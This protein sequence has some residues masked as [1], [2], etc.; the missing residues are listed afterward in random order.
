MRNVTIVESNVEPNKE[1]LWFYNGKLKWFGPNGWEE[2]YSQALSPTTTPKPVVPPATT[3]TTTSTAPGPGVDT[4]PIGVRVYNYMDVTIDTIVFGANSV[5]RS[6]PANGDIYIE[7]VYPSTSGGNITLYI[8]ARGSGSTSSGVQV[9]RFLDVNIMGE[10]SG[11]SIEQYKSILNE[12]TI[13]IPYTGSDALHSI[14]LVVSISDGDTT[15]TSSPIPGSDVRFTNNTNTDIQ[16]YGVLY[17]GDTASPPMQPG[18]TYIL[19]YISDGV[20]VYNSPNYMPFDSLRIT[21]FKGKKQED[22]PCI[23]DTD[24]IV[25]GVMYK[26]PEGLSWEEIT[27]IL[28]EGTIQGTGTTSSTPTPNSIKF[29][30]MTDV[31]LTLTKVNGVDEGLQPPPIQPNQ[32]YILVHNANDA[33]TDSYIEIFAT[34]ESDVL[35]PFSFLKITAFKDG[36][37]EYD[38]PYEHYQD[39]MEISLYKFSFKELI[40]KGFTTVSINGN[41]SNPTTTTTTTTSSSTPTPI[42]EQQ[43]LVSN[44]FIGEDGP[45]FGITMDDNINFNNVVP[46][47]LESL[48]PYREGIYVNYTPSSRYLAVVSPKTNG[49][50]DTIVATILVP[51]DGSFEY[52][53]HTLY[54]INSMDNESSKYFLFDLSKSPYVGTAAYSNPRVELHNYNSHSISSIPPFIDGNIP[55]FADEE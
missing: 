5:N 39:A 33:N 42:T 30:N 47:R 41:I 23:I 10:I 55:P 7:G 22:V 35:P 9:N 14:S 31:S 53:S 28:I 13:D 49:F 20:A 1:H 51:V 32:Q 25:N 54:P 45:T 46:S 3:T 52:E 4:T 8:K 37:P 2:I 19:R 16:I 43:I 21:A 18:Q 17:N 15:T 48:E 11:T 40:E 36:G 6:I 26:F 29:T 34:P 27:E 44:A 24:A 12:G 38:V 50:K